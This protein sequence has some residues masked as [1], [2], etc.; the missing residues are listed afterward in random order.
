MAGPLCSSI[1]GESESPMR[2][3]ATRSSSRARTAAVM[4]LCSSTREV[5]EHTCP[6][7]HR[8]PTQR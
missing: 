2:T 5:A 4:F 1:S 8:M 6:E 7:P 3:P